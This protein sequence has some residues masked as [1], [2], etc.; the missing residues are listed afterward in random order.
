MEDRV[1]PPFGP[2]APAEFEHPPDPGG[3]AHLPGDGATDR[4][5]PIIPRPPRPDPA[6]RPG[7]PGHRRRKPAHRFRCRNGGRGSHR[8]SRAWHPDR[9]P[10]RTA[11]ATGRVPETR[12]RRRAPA[13]VRPGREVRPRRRDTAPDS[14][15]HRPFAPARRAACRSGPQPAAAPPGSL[16]NRALGNASQSPARPTDTA[17]VTTSSRVGHGG[18]AVQAPIETLAVPRPGGPRRVLAAGAGPPLLFLHQ[19][20]GRPEDYAAPGAGRLLL[21][22]AGHGMRVLAPDLPGHGLAAASRRFPAD[23]IERAAEDALAVLETH[24]PGPAALLGIGVGAHVAAAIARRAPEAVT[25]LALDTPSR[26]WPGA[27]AEPW[28]GFTGSRPRRRDRARWER[29]AATLPDTVEAF[30]ASCEPCRVPTLFLGTGAEGGGPD[31]PERTPVPVRVW[32]CR[33]EGA[34]ALVQAETVARRTLERF[35]A[36]HAAP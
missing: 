27:P 10:T 20:F 13:A 12:A 25:A 34:P 9:W 3:G 18:V 7:R 35:L 21:W 30:L 36:A 19:A 32:A 28:P 4:H 22:L 1:R 16:G 6:A 24:G 5:G 26:L 14:L 11:P 23:L 8:A 17:V 2:E 15:A 29:I 31:V 33:G